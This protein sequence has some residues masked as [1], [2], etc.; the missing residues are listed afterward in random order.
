[1][2]QVLNGVLEAKE[3]V[4]SFGGTV[5]IYEIEGV[6]PEKVMAAMKNSGKR[7]LMESR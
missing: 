6:E 5:K 4:E 7:G 2:Q 3:E 1:M